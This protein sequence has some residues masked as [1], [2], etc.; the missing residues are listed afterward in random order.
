MHCLK[1][2]CYFCSVPDKQLWITV[3]LLGKWEFQSTGVSGKVGGA[4]SEPGLAEQQRADPTYK[5]GGQKPEI[6]RQVPS[7]R[8]NQNQGSGSN[9]R[10][11][12]NPKSKSKGLGTWSEALGGRL[13]GGAGGRGKAQTW[14]KGSGGGTGT[15]GARGRGADKEGK[16]QGSMR[17][18]SGPSPCCCFSLHNSEGV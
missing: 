14:E 18:R 16:G 9:L 10:S 15:E 3:E 2:K 1:V 4:R 11:N 8:T 6:R 7:Q 5:A 12:L 17:W 13:Q